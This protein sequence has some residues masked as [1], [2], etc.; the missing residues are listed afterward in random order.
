MPNINRIHLPDGNTY[1]LVKK[2]LTRA[3]YDALTEEEKNNGIIK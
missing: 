1:D 3:E 2:E